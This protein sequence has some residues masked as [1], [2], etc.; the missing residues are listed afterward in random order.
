MFVCVPRGVC[1]RLSDQQCLKCHYCSNRLCFMLDSSNV[2]VNVWLFMCSQGAGLCVCV[3][4]R[5]CM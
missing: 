2:C 3:C 1:V 5:L 4:I